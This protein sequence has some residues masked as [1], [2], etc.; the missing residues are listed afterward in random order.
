MNKT[1]A[2]AIALVL[3]CGTFTF[4]QDTTSVNASAARNE[5]S[6]YEKPQQ[7]RDRILAALAQNPSGAAQYTYK[8]LSA[9]NQL[10]NHYRAGELS[11]QE[12]QALELYKTGQFDQ[13]YARLGF[14]L[15]DIQRN[16]LESGLWIDQSFT[17]QV[18]QWPVKYQF[19]DS[20]SYMKVHQLAAA[21]Q[22]TLEV[23]RQK[24][25][26]LA[27]TNPKRALRAYALA[28]FQRMDGL[29]NRFAI[30]EMTQEDAQAIK[31]YKNGDVREA[32]EALGFSLDKVVNAV[33]ALE[34]YSQSMH[35]SN[36]QWP[37]KRL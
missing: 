23:T 21:R 6:R 34:F 27:Q 31:F 33:E 4:A 5:Y 3:T 24:V 29:L 12:R 17:L 32:Y 28:Y 37:V 14:N 9:K 36:F 10:I 26:E 22:I 15:D 2:S 35:A 1:I 18:F 19:K 7:V 30:N 13:A 11:Q 20:G 25:E 16:I 8:L